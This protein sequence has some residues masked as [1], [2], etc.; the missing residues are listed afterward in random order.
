MNMS[1]V[2]HDGFD[3]RAYQVAQKI[4][5]PLTALIKEGREQFPATSPLIEDLFYS[6]YKAAPRLIEKDDLSLSD[7]VLH[8]VVSEV[9]GTRD[10][11]AI[12]QTGTVGD[13]LYS[14]IAA[15]TVGK[16]VVQSLS[17]EV[18]QK[19]TELMQTEEEMH[20]LFVETSVLEDL[21]QENPSKSLELQPRIEAAKNLSEVKK[22]EAERIAQSLESQ[23]EQIED[24][25]RQAGR[26]A[27]QS[28][29]QTIENMEQA[30]QAFT[31]GHDE[32]KSMQISGGPQMTTKEKVELANRVSKSRSLQQIAAL[33]GRMIWT[34]Q[35]IQRTKVDTPPDTVMGITMGRDLPKV[36][37]SEFAFLTHPG[38][39]GLFYEKWDQRKLLQY[40]MKGNE[41]LGQGP[42]IVAFDQ[43]GS[44][45]ASLPGSSTSKSDWSKAVILALLAI[46]RKQ[47]RDLIIICFDEP[48]YV[49]TYD[50]P[51][52]E[53]STQKFLAF[54]EDPRCGGETYYECWMN[55]AIETAETSRFDKAD[56][57]CIGDGLPNK[58]SKDWPQ[59]QDD[60]NTRRKAKGMRCYSVLFGDKTGERFLSGISDDVKTISDMR[61][62]NDALSMMFNI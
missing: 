58:F 48:G 30:M 11:E 22:A 12:R 38:L 40:D 6:L 52:G 62:D 17:D 16:S 4:H 24:S 60:W 13:E 2:S 36:I 61:E 44:M 28:A 20:R 55:E 43:S 7:H 3:S 33:A 46:A 32:G 34:A 56:I 45:R 27:S 18:S 19:I 8:K 49:K 21:A 9:T 14:A 47:K 57:I 23:S 50:F 31:G 29:G 51:K 41:K 10:W 26:S 59:V 53:V 39:K 37:P 1:V 15:S 35:A 42:I 25:A 54:A 5:D